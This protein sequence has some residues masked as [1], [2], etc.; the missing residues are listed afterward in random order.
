MSSPLSD[1]SQVTIASQSQNAAY[2]GMA[3]AMVG[4]QCQLHGF[5]D[6][7]D[8]IPEEAQLFVGRR[9]AFPDFI[10]LLSRVI[11]FPF[12]VLLIVFCVIPVE[13]INCHALELSLTWLACTRHPLQHITI[14]LRVRAIFKESPKAVWVFGFLWLSTCASILFP[15]L[16]RTHKTLAR[17]AEYALGIMLKDTAPPVS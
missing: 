7:L 1:Q 10:Y 12:M 15:F 11:T 6:L 5:G 4:L 16:F 3:I 9:L 2:C 13:F 8:G 14:L 17:I